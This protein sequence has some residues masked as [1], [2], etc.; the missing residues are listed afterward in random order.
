MSRSPFPAPPVLVLPSRRPGPD[1]DPGLARLPRRREGG[2]REGGRRVQQGQRR[3]IKVTT[4]RHPLRRLHG[5][6][7]APPCRA[8]W[9]RTS[10]S[11]RRTGSAAGWRPA[12]PSSRSTSS[13]MTPTKERFLPTTLE[14]MTYRGTVYGLPLNF[15]VITLIYN[16]KLVPT[17][18]KTTGELLAMSKKLPNARPARRPRLLVHRLLLP[19]GADERLRRPR[20]RPGPKPRSTRPRT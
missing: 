14:A 9:G 2:L 16:K 7:H 3:Q 13:S 15:K 4:A 6:D 10:S 5:Q 8:A 19:R 18:P 1:G 20:V 17:P 12:T 11:S